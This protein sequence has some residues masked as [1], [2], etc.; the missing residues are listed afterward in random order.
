MVYVIKSV[1]HISSRQL[2]TSEGLIKRQW[3]SR[4]N[5]IAAETGQDFL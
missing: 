1:P 4:V 5:S 3:N 2:H